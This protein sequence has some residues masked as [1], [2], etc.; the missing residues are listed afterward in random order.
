MGVSGN[1]IAIKSFQS[2]A[3]NEG[4]LQKVVEAVKEGEKQAKSSGEVRSLEVFYHGFRQNIRIGCVYIVPAS[5]C[6]SAKDF[7]VALLYGTAVR[8]LSLGEEMADL[9]DLRTG[10]EFDETTDVE[11][12]LKALKEQ[13]FTV[14]GKSVSLVVFAPAWAGIREYVCFQYTDDDA[15]LTD[16]LRHLV[17][18]CYFNPALSSGFD[19]LMTTVDTWKFDVT[20][21]TPK[22]T[23]PASTE[24]PFRAYPELMKAAASRDRVFLT[25]RTADALAKEQ[26]EPSEM[27]VFESLG[28]ALGKA[29]STTPS[30]RR[31]RPALSTRSPTPAQRSP[32]PTTARGRR[33]RAACPTATPA[34]STGRPGQT[35]P[36]PPAGRAW[37]RR[38]LSRRRRRRRRG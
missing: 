30:P 10:S 18:A 27:N 26:V 11:A 19:A 23:Y 37:A 8:L 9:I 14:E 31:R 24:S 21:I 15:K 3:V 22:L 7:P 6:D 34:A 17:F 29:L 16:L 28:E 36:A 4:L 38:R 20:D 35:G 33:R 25:V 1:S 2:F 32:G 5:V 12:H 13:A